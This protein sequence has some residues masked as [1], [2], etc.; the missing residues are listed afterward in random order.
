LSE[1]K[2]TAILIRLTVILLSYNRIRHARLGSLHNRPDRGWLG[3]SKSYID[4][5]ERE[6]H[7][8]SKSLAA[9][10][11]SRT[12]PVLR[13]TF[14]IQPECKKDVA[15]QQYHP[16]D[17]RQTQMPKLRVL[18]PKRFKQVQSNSLDVAWYGRNISPDC[19][20]NSDYSQFILNPF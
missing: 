3:N 15:D 7:D 5:G 20:Y 9:I 4:P 18:N 11:K 10:V 2:T 17:N 8:K 1:L 12:L 13:H 14:G 19:K 16:N 6:S